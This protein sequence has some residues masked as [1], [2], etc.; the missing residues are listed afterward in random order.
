MNWTPEKIERVGELLLNQRSLTEIGAKMGASRNAIS[1]LI[2]RTP[3]LRNMPG[4]NRSNG[5][6]KNVGNTYKTRSDKGVPRAAQLL[7]IK[8]NRKQGGI[9]GGK[10]GKA[11]IEARQAK[12]NLHAGNIQ[13]KREA[14]ASDPIYREPIPAI[15]ASEYDANCPRVSLV[16]RRNNQCVFPLGDPLGGD[17]AFCGH[18]RFSAYSY[19][20][21]HCVRAYQ[22]FT[23]AEAR[24]A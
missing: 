23:C 15:G 5:Y 8:A 21:Q 13:N 2:M 19:C 24:A 4:R 17:F 18:P 22:N 12:Q 10:P 6:R 1:A 3:A 7:S 9:L 14:R 11:L 20:L 16:E